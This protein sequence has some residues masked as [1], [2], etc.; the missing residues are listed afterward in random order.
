MFSLHDMLIHIPLPCIKF[1]RAMLIGTNSHMHIHIMMD[2][3]YIYHAHNFFGLCLF[4]VGTH[5]YLSTSQSHVL[6]KRALESNDDLGSHGLPFPSLSSPKDFAH[7][8][9][10]ALTWLWLI[11][12]MYHLPILPCSLCMICSFLCLC[13]AFVS[14]ALHYT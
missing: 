10:M 6:T 14:H 4:C 5:D 12:H 11:V 9:Y 3:V 7:F 8:L 13:H 2:D 1:L